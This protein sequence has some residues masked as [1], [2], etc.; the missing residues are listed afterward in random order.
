MGGEKGA[1]ETHPGEDHGER[2]VFAEEYVSFVGGWAEVGTEG[3]RRLLS[4]RG[5]V[6]E[7][8]GWVGFEDRLG[9][10]VHKWCMSMLKRR[11]KESKQ[12]WEL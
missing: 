6:D 3:A 12:R 7:G 4:L 11:W 8:K 10:V 1:E 2:L 5:G 9:Q